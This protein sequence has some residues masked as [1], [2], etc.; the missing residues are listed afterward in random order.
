[1]KS[2]GI[3]LVLAA[4]IISA[5]DAAATPINITANRFIVMGDNI[6]TNVFGP[7]SPSTAL[8][9]F[10]DSLTLNLGDEEVTANQDSNVGS[11]GQFSGNGLAQ[12]GFSVLENEGIFSRSE[13]AIQF[14]ITTPHSYVL[15]GELEAGVDGGRGLAQ[16]ALGGATPLGFTAL[17]FGTTNLASTGTLAPG[18]YTL[19]VLALMDT[20]TVDLGSF[21][22]GSASYDFNF[23]IRE[24]IDPNPTPEPLSVSLLAFGLVLLGI[25][26]RA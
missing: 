26:R 16:F 23:S 8:G 21:M 1:M 2:L 22:G 18:S 6:P 11:S 5:H 17:D 14:E 10:F 20:G 7:A 13:Y 4:S 12:V 15:S 25:R 24:I 9:G 19:I 3:G